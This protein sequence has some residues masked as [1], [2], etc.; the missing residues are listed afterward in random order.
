MSRVVQLTPTFSVG[1]A[2]GNDMVAMHGALLAM[3]FESEIYALG[4]AEKAKK[5]GKL[6][7]EYKPRESDILLYHM[8]IG[9]A[10]SELVMRVKVRKKIMV[11]HNITPAQYLAELP[12]L[13][14]L[15]G[16]GR[17][18]LAQLAGHIDCALAD[19]AYNALELE[20]LG[21]RDI[22]VLPILFDR[23]AF[24][25]APYNQ[26]LTQR[27]RDGMTNLL[28]VGRIASNK[29]QEDII[30]AYHLYNR[31][32]NPNSRLLIVGG[33]DGREDYKHALDALVEKLGAKNVILTGAVPFADILAYYRAAD[34]FLC[35]S[36][37]EGFCVPLLEAMALDVPI[38]ASHA[39]AVPGTLGD[40]GVMVV[41]RDYPLI[42][43]VL[44]EVITNA[45]LRERLIEGQRA[46]LTAFDYHAVLT[47]FQDY[48]RKFL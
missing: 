27:C 20:E 9:S 2:V 4:V 29:R 1:D 37:H 43:E 42:A 22:Q 44:H 8:S 28:F 33:Y 17:K 5:L 40:S 19:S 18:Q 24:V 26:A 38:I 10:L 6:I 45:A 15:C 23:E 34:V 25:S 14:A 13:A 41:S 21:Y 46:R 30:K 12:E 16:A 35:M 48:M 7:G 39:A 31:H 11:Y 3:G 36:E 32:I 47:Q